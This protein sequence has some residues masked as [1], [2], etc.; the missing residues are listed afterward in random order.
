MD[1]VN[2]IF[3]PGPVPVEE[4]I[5]AIGAGQP[6]Y[7]RTDEFSH[8]THEILYGLKHVFQTSGEVALLT[9]SG[10][11]AMEAAVLNF[12]TTS[13]KVI[14]VNGGTF[15]QRWCEL[16]K[17]HSIPFREIKLEAGADLDLDRL[18]EMC[19]EENFSAFL[20]NA[21]ETS[22]GQLYGVQ[23]IGKIVRDF[24][25]L[26]I[27]DAISTI[28]AD[29]FQM[30]DW[31]VD[32]A[33]LSSQKALALPPGLSFVA[34]GTRAIARLRQIGPKTLYLD[35]HDYL[36]NQA[37]GQVPYTPAIVLLLQLHRRLLDIQQHTLRETIAQH[38]QR[39]SY[40]REAIIDLPFSVLPARPSNAMTALLCEELDAVHVVRDLR[41]RY[42]IEVAPSDGAL[43]HKLIRISHMGAQNSAD[44]DFIVG[45]LGNVAH[46]Q[47]VKRISS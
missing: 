31:N 8:L 17:I 43:K 5:R 27:V 44:T 1:R 12:L 18:R 33:I 39:S 21:H 26:Y 46:P 30:D 37:R 35:L 3:T 9:G 40:F 13:D 10:T 6:P 41:A 34:M 45:A 19:G 14:V 11:L 42:A 2:K 15:G 23:A 32:V 28:C 25:L 24:G 38:A 7:N 36:S 20:I 4:H 22:T 47:P 29:P 16:C